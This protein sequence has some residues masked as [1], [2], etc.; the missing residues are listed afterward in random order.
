VHTEPLAKVY[1]GL[2]LLQYLV[3]LVAPEWGVACD[4]FEVEYAE[5]PD[6]DLVVVGPVLDHLGRHVL[7]GS[8]EGL[9][10]AQ[11]CRK[12]EVA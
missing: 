7:I 8:T 3:G 11:N 5:C 4:H 2:H 10:F 1:L 6:V 9:P 12:T